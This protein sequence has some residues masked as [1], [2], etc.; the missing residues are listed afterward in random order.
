VDS[1]LAKDFWGGTLGNPSKLFV[2]RF[3]SFIPCHLRVFA[4]AESHLPDLLGQPCSLYSG[5]SFFSL[6]FDLLFLVQ[7]YILYRGADP[8]LERREGSEV[9]EDEDQEQGTVDERTPLAR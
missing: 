2:P 4:R 1:W 5:L 3:S 6:A 9:D 7:H 8:I